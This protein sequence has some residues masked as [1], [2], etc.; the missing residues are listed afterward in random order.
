MQGLPGQVRVSRLQPQWDA[1]ALG[2]VRVKFPTQGQGPSKGSR[3]RGARGCRVTC[4]GAGGA[5]SGETEARR[6]TAGA[7]QGWELVGSGEKGWG[8][9]RAGRECGERGE[10]GE[11]KGGGWGG[12]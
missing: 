11:A 8:E 2:R 10:Q 9:G 12:E 3:T 6:D 5:F 7:Q 1:A 4:E